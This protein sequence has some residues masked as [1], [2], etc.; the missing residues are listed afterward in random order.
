MSDDEQVMES[1]SSPD[2]ISDVT[3]IVEDKK[4]FAHKSILGKNQISFRH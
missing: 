1:F 2:D 3:I 4:I